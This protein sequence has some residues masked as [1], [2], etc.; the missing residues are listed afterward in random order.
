M[1]GSLDAIIGALQKA[2]YEERLA[3]LTG[4]VYVPRS[5]GSESDD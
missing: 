3:A 4:Q 2:D 1:E 5:V